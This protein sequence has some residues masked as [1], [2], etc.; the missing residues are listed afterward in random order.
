M[1]ENEN[2][3]EVTET[4]APATETAVT[5]E[6]PSL[7]KRVWGG[8]KEYCRKSVVKLKRRPM[9]IAFLILAISTVINLCYLGN[10]SQIGRINQFGDNMR[11]LCIFVNQLF[12]ILVLL[13]FMNSFPKRSKKPKIVQLVLTFVFMAVMIGIDVYLYVT[14][15]S[16]ASKAYAVEQE[17]ASP[18]YYDVY[19]GAVTGALVHLIFVAI[20]AVLTATYPLYGKLINMI[21]TRKDIGESQLSEEIDTSEEEE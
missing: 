17:V 15:T 21:N 14:W 16:A 8:I 11:G 4:P 1:A 20:A 9:N 6:K 13:L 3:V 5:E 10:Y 19:S 2:V 18:G 12:C 7:G